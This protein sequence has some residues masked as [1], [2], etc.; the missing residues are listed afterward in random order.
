MI[1]ATDVSIGMA[2]GWFTIT[3]GPFSK[4]GLRWAAQCTCGTEVE[5]TITTINAKIE[6]NGSCQAC[7]YQRGSKHGHGS[8]YNPTWSVW[9]AMKQR[10]A[11]PRNKMFDRYGGRG[12]AVCERWRNSFE[13]FLSDMGER[14]SRSH[15][16]ERENNDG[17]Y[18]PGNCRWATRQ[19]QNLNT[20]RTV[21]LTYGGE[22]FIG[23]AALAKR[24][25]VKPATLA[26]RDQ[27]G[28]LG[29]YDI[30]RLN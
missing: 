15:S 13:A 11:N 18:E 24:L 5:L 1:A 30:T 23:F 8:T 26:G 27:R 22:T 2:A 3:A 7:R 10:C 17:N 4:N 29:N 20:S 6:K 25:G 12:I 21:K 9:Q 19:E 14:P 16:I 28:T